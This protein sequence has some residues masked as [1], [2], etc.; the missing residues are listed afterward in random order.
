MVLKGG[1]LGPSF[2]F[3]FLRGLGV[4]TF[5]GFFQGLSNLPKVTPTVAPERE[6]IPESLAWDLPSFVN[7][8]NAAPPT[9]PSFVHFLT[10]KMANDHNSYY[11][12][13]MI[14]L[15]EYNCSF[16]GV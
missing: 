14:T 8:S 16:K 9:P 15:T 2:T 12:E 7:C 3:F 4:G 5:V 6:S 1:L 11:S 10:P 13:W